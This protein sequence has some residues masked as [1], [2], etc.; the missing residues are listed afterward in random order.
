[1]SSNKVKLNHF[2]LSDELLCSIN[3]N[4]FFLLS[5][6]VTIIFLC[7]YIYI[8]LYTYTIV[9]FICIYSYVLLVGIVSL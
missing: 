1:M 6:I 3:I 5:F 7:I 4:K 8:V 2:N 9:L